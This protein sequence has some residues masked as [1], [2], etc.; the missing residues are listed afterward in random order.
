MSKQI[1]VSD[2]LTFVPSSLDTTNS[3]YP[4]T[5]YDTHVLE[6]AFDDVSSSSR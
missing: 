6:N 5:Y 3:N 4:G 1:N 2:T